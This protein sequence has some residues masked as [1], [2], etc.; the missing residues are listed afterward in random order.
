MEALSISLKAAQPT[1][2]PCCY[3]FGLSGQLISASLCGF[4]D[5]STKAYAGV[6]YLLF[7]IV[8][9]LSVKFVTSKTR[10]T[11]LKEETIPQL[12]LLSALFLARLLT[13]VTQSL[14]SE[15]ALLP[16]QCLTDSTLALCWIKETTK[17]QKTFVQSCVD[18]IRRLVPPG[19]SSHCLGKENWL[20]YLQG[21]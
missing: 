7:E 10:V 18:E 2:I 3:L 20:I 9:E 1:V 11:P 6:V 17:T 19:S 4:C 8:A 16:T 14:E 5:A 21:A 12:E 15:L 13:T